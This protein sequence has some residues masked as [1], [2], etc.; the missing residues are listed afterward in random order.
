MK[1]T[2]ITRRLDGKIAS[3]IY[4]GYQGQTNLDWVFKIKIMARPLD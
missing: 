4:L 2:R 1:N 3:G